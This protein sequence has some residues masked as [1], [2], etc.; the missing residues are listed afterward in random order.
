MS[1]QKELDNSYSKIEC[2]TDG[3]LIK[4]DTQFV[5]STLSDRISE[6]AQKV[7]IRVANPLSER[8]KTAG[9]TSI[10]YTTSDDM[11]QNNAANFTVRQNYRG[12]AYLPIRLPGE[13]AQFLHSYLQAYDR[14][15][16]GIIEWIHHGCVVLK[17]VLFLQKSL[18]MNNG[19]AEMNSWMLLNDSKRDTQLPYSL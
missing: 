10:Q 2:V 15:E 8:R 11:S 19:I 6:T 5:Q 16:P 14:R 9:T 13:N 17:V 4:G 18:Y 1:L 3:L 7:T 12:A